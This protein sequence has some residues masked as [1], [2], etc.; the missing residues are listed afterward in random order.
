M[1]IRVHGLVLYC[2]FDSGFVSIAK[3]LTKF[4]EELRRFKGDF[5]CQR[6]FEDL[7]ES[8]LSS[9]SLLSSPRPE[10]SSSFTWTQEINFGDGA[11]L[12]QTLGGHEQVINY[13]SN[14]LS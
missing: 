3:P 4:T 12:S 13:F 11:V 1:H 9:A 5:N 7:V 14:V 8:M 2:R 10:G 6:D